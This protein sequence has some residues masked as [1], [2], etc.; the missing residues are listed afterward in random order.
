MTLINRFWTLNALALS[1]SLFSGVIVPNR[2]API[3]G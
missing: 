3:P 2:N 1:S